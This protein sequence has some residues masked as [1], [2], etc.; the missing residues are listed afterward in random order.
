[1]LPSAANFIQIGQI[2]LVAILSG[3]LMQHL[4]VADDGVERGAQLMAHV[5]DESALGVV[6]L[7]GQQLGAF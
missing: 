7:L 2:V 1:M 3:Y 6:R 5:G 4:T